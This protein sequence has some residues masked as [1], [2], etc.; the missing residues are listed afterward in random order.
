MLPQTD[1]KPRK[2]PANSSPCDSLSNYYSAVS[3]IDESASESNSDEGIDKNEN[4]NQG[5]ENLQLANDSF[6]SPLYLLSQQDPVP[7]LENAPPGSHLSSKSTH[8]SLFTS[9]CA[10]PPNSSSNQEQEQE[11][12]D[13]L[14]TTKGPFSSPG[15]SHAQSYLTSSSFS[16]TSQ[17]NEFSYFVPLHIAVQQDPCGIFECIKETMRRIEDLVGV[18][19][20]GREEV[21]AFR[22]THVEIV[23]CIESKFEVVRLARESGPGFCLGPEMQIQRDLVM[24]ANLEEGLGMGMRLRIQR[25]NRVVNGLDPLAPTIARTDRAA[26]ALI[27]DTY[28]LR[29]IVVA[30]WSTG[31]AACMG[32]GTGADIAKIECIGRDA[33]R[34]SG[35]IGWSCFG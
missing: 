27:A 30:S 5:L 8:A 20:V 3:H 11:Q 9:G 25:E 4:K 22:S 13:I 17:K 12:E 26:T 28:T 10:S 21:D 16:G 18:L 15:D 34:R 19:G 2:S 1:A 29:G 33:G 14:S 35:G 32:K 7:G 23:K 31:T 6:T 24:S